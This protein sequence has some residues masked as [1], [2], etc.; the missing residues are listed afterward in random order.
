MFLHYYFSPFYNHWKRYFTGAGALDH[1]SC[2]LGEECGSKDKTKLIEQLLAHDGK[3]SEASCAPGIPD[4]TTGNR[5]RF[6]M[7]PC[8][9]AERILPEQGQARAIFPLSQSEKDGEGGFDR[10]TLEI[11]NFDLTDFDI[12]ECVETYFEEFDTTESEETKKDN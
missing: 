5:L 9:S 4:D 2:H 8:E 7:Q 10:R 6:M 11:R 12:T 1:T 3:I